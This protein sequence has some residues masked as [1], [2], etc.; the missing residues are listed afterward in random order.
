MVQTLGSFAGF[1]GTM[2]DLRLA[3]RDAVDPDPALHHV[4]RLRALFL[5]VRR[6]RG[7]SNAEPVE[8]HRREAPLAPEQTEDPALD[9]EVAD[10]DERR[11]VL[12]RLQPELQPVAVDAE[13]GKRVDFEALQFDL[14][15]MLS[16]SA[17]INFACRIGARE[18]KCRATYRPTS[19]PPT[20]PMNQRTTFRCQ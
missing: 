16:L 15:S 14:A 2:I 20:I 1:L 19:V 9:L 17:S 12:L 6:A 11:R 10:F 3:R 7:N 8:V 5:V 4:R 13:R 18:T